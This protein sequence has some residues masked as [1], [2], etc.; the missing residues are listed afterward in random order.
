MIVD[1]FA[2][3]A[4]WDEGLKAL[5]RRD[6]IGLEV[7]ETACAT[8]EAAGH[9]RRL[10]DV[11]DVNPAEYAGAEG[12]I[13]SPPCDPFSQNGHRRGF[14]D[15]RGQL[16]GQILRWAEGMRPQWIACEQVPDAMR[17]FQAIGRDLRGLGYRTGSASWAGSAC[18]APM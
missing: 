5:G 10:V 17:W 7:D 2:G 18:Q 11:A 15:P 14:E 3:P 9:A 8:A 4:G 6:V 12:L 1:L 13:A 16:M